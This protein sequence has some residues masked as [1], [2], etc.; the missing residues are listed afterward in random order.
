MKDESLL[1]SPLTS[2][3]DWMSGTITII[4]PSLISYSGT[5]TYRDFRLSVK[6]LDIFMN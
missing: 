6:P 1:W 5:S 3:E 2:T 4:Y